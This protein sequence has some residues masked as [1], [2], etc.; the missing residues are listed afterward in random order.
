M[1]ENILPS[2]VGGDLVAPIGLAVVGGVVADC[3]V[4][5]MRNDTRRHDPDVACDIGSDWASRWAFSS[6]PCSNKSWPVTDVQ[7]C[8]AKP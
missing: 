6:P 1:L 5:A 2:G 8:S 4:G 3:S 7:T